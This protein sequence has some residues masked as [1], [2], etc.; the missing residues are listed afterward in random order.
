M[1]RCHHGQDV[2][3]TN[4][5]IENTLSNDN[6]NNNNNNNKDKRKPGVDG[7]ARIVNLIS[8]Q[9]RTFTPEESLRS[10]MAVATSGRGPPSLLLFLSSLSVPSS[11]VSHTLSSFLSLS[12]PS[13]T[14]LRLF[15]FPFRARQTSFCPFRTIY[16]FREA[17][18]HASSF[19]CGQVV[20]YWD[21]D[22]SIDHRLAEYRELKEQCFCLT[23]FYAL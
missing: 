7:V 11:L 13:H 14:L 9:P 18:V 1:T 15:R 5:N 8:C 4:R 21:Q 10:A 6:D 3:Q 16:G 2:Q 17:R 12:E 19:L 23:A 20:H 22:V